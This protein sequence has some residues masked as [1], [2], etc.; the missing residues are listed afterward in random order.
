MP[1]EA[2]RVEE[3]PHSVFRHELADV[4]AGAL[5]PRAL[6]P[7]ADTL[8]VRATD[9]QVVERSDP[10]FEQD[11]ASLD[12]TALARQEVDG[13]HLAEALAQRRVAPGLELEPV[14]R[15]VEGECLAVDRGRARFG[16]VLDP[17][18]R[19]PRMRAG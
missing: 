19:A 18:A 16:H 1:V 5:R 9:G 3:E 14:H 17:R 7:R 15:G 8:L 13:V 11:A 10:C 4:Q 6:E 12:G 2:A